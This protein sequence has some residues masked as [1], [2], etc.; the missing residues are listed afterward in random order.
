MYVPECGVCLCV[1]REEGMPEGLKRTL[2]E[3]SRKSED[4]GTHY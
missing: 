4:G 2:T 1:E 3:K